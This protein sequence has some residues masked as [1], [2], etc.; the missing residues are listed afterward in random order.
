VW[1]AFAAGVSLLAACAIEGDPQEIQATAPVA[2]V[3]Q[4]D[5]IAYVG[6]GAL[7]GPDGTELKPDAA[8][9]FAVQAQYRRTL[10]GQVD[11]TMAERSRALVNELVREGIS[12]DERAFLDDKLIRSLAEASSHPDAMALRGKSVTLHRAY[13]RLRGGRADFPAIEARLRSVGLEEAP[14][15]SSEPASLVSSYELDCLSAGVPVPPAW[16]TA[17]WVSRGQLTK[18]FISTDLLASVYYWSSS[19]P[20]GTCIALPRSNGFN[21][22]LLGVICHGVDTS[23]ACF[24]DNA[25]VA[26]G[27]VV[28]MSSFVKGNNPAIADGGMCTG[29]HAGEN[30]FVIH[31]STP[32]DL[33]PVV[34][35]DRWYAKNWY[36]PLIASN[37]PQNPGP[38]NAIA[39][40]PVGAGQ[41]SCQGCHT[42]GQRLPELS[43][44]SFGFCGSV[45][46]NA[47]GQGFDPAVKTMPP[48]LTNLS[49]STH[50]NAL[51]A[52]CTSSP[53]AAH[54][55]GDN[56]KICAQAGGYCERAFS[57]T[58]AR[59]DLCRWPN[60]GSA[61]S[62]ASTAGIWTSSTSGFALGWPT[63][64]P[65]GAA[66]ACITQM[67]NIG[68]RRSIESA[69]TTAN[70]ELCRRRGG[71][72]EDASSTTG[73]N[74]QLCRWPN[75]DTATKCTSTAGIWTTKASGF[76]LTW[77]T[78][79]RAD[80]LGSCITQM[81]NLGGTPN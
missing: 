17:G 29:C 25:D 79:V 23:K 36:D 34:P 69:C 57:T 68:G 8:F 6:H 46:K 40:L 18:P 47:V 4:E 74:H 53:L 67:R 9:V 71:F 49:F 16:G 5:P 22:D 20:R 13:R 32:L 66:G 10:E 62:C 70:R 44:S 77:P 28:P 14:S 75:H 50:I 59:H 38:T 3:E 35:A 30:P 61:A 7:F 41:G 60:A 78:A 2:I 12:A 52:R 80:E 27:E 54:C 42:L 65:A 58:G 56:A 15:K 55:V 31:P 63:A 21:I 33:A 19:S 43:Q 81:A 37:L 26:I 24:W 1:A 39:A 48:F 73:G 76:A 11:P 72:C 51:N 45:F 64:V